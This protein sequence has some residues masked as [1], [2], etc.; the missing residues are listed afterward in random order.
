MG[1]FLKTCRLCFI[2][3][4]MLA[5]PRVLYPIKQSRSFISRLMRFIVCDLGDV[6]TGD[7]FFSMQSLKTNIINH[8]SFIGM[9]KKLKQ[10]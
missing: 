8:L 2:R 5:A 3:Y 9:K 10:C 4:K 6:K 1:R 7:R